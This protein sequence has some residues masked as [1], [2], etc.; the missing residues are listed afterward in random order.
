MPARK[1]RPR[2]VTQPAACLGQVHADGVG[3]NHGADAEAGYHAEQ[4]EGRGQPCPVFAQTVLDEVHGPAHPVA[5]GGL[6]TKMHGEQ[7]F[8]K[9]GHHAHQGGHP[10]PEQRARSA[11]G[12]GRS[13]AH[14]VAGADVRRQGGHQR[15]PGGDFAMLGLVLASLPQASVGPTP[16]TEGEK[17]QP[18]GQIQARA[19]QHDQHDRTP[20]HIADR[21]Q[22]IIHRLHCPLRLFRISAPLRGLPRAGGVPQGNARIRHV[23]TAHDATPS[24]T[25]MAS[26]F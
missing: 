18:D 20:Y 19:H 12:N 17:T 23:W 9:F 24:K 22:K 1:N 26:R 10:H 15:V 21:L 5:G 16:V 7:H 2:A 8:G 14:N 25:A 11:Q 3:L 6:F 13:H 4:G